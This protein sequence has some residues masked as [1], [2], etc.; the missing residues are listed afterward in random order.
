M[1]QNHSQEH[2]PRHRFRKG[3]I[4]LKGI[5]EFIKKNNGFLYVL[6]SF[7]LLVLF[8]LIPLCMT[9]YFSFTEYSVLN[10][11]YGNLYACYGSDTDRTVTGDCQSAGFPVPGEARQLF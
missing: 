7:L 6:P 2:V 10:P 9:G 3:I 5:Q 1:P 11:Q 8:S 4:C